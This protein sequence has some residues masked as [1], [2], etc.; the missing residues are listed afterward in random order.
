MLLYVLNSEMGVSADILSDFLSK[1][2]KL[3][4]INIG[5]GLKNPLS[6][7]LLNKHFNFSDIHLCPQ[8]AD[9]VLA[10]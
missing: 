8:G 5:N 10:K 2:F 6:V 7:C 3:S 4:N 9:A 1:I